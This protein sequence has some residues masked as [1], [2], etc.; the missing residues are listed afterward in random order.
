MPKN[1]NMDAT[2]YLVLME[3][4]LRTAVFFKGQRL[5]LEEMGPHAFT[6]L[7]Y[8]LARPEL[9]VAKPIRHAA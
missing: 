7:N 9:E 5:T 4:H 2:Y 8:S 6:L 3:V 1:M